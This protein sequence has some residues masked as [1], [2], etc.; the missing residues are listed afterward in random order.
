MSLDTRSTSGTALSA[1]GHSARWLVHGERLPRT[2]LDTR[3]TSGT[4]LSAFGH[5]V[6]SAWRTVTS[7]VFGRSVNL[8]DC[9]ECLRTL[10]G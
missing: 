4:A 10:G 7:N 6:V 9:L 2:S 8:L 3:S 1:F 5:S